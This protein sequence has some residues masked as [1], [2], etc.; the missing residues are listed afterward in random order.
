[1]TINDIQSQMRVR[2]S[3]WWDPDTM[4][5]FRTRTVGP[6]FE[7]P[8]GIYF[9][10]SDRQYDDSRAYCVRRYDPTDRDISTVGEIGQYKS[11]TGAIAKARKLAGKGAT[12]NDEPLIAVTIRE[13]F[14]DDCRKHGN[15]KCTMSEC[16]R[17]RTIA[18]RHHR[19]MEHY[20]NGREMYDAEDEPIGPLKRLRHHGAALAK[21]IGAKGIVFS[22]D[23]RGCTV[24]LTWKTGETNDWGNEGW[25]VPIE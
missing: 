19:M 3:H 18:K 20:C 23:P 25:V 1:M 10:T 6:V 22:G 12:A 8:G 16:D 15:P 17:L 7:G 14:I 11:R 13:Q 9:A 24:K 4:R 21:S 5:F 2:G